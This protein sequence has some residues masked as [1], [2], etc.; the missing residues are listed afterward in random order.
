M[1]TMSAIYAAQFAA[2]CTPVKVSVILAVV[3]MALFMPSGR[4]GAFIL[5]A[6]VQT[7]VVYGLC[8]IDY[9]VLAWIAAI[10]WPNYL[11]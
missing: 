4:L 7:A 2:L 6:A 1:Y 10:F 3:T 9:P 8:K 5:S 11:F